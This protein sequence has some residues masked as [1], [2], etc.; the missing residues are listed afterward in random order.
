LATEDYFPDGPYMKA[1]PFGNFALRESVDEAK[2]HD[3]T[4]AGGWD[5][6]KQVVDD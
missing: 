2:N 1:E 6:P 4:V 5:A 3:G